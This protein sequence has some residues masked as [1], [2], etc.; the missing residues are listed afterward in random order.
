[1]TDSEFGF[2]IIA[3]SELSLADIPR[4][5]ASWHEMMPFALS[6]DGYS[7]HGFDLCARIANERRNKTLTELRTCLF[8][9]QRKFRHLA[10]NPNKREMAYIQKLLKSIRAKVSSGEIE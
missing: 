8:F 1:M 4:D 3:N 10:Q 2:P 5:E 7:I 9:E 6:F